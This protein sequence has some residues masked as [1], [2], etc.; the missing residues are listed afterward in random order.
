M[1]D[2]LID[3]N[4]RNSLIGEDDVTP[5]LP[6]RVKVKNSNKALYVH[7]AS[8]VVE[9]PPTATATTTSVAD[10]ASSTDLLASNSARLGA[11]V[12]NDSSA[13]LYINL[14]DAASTSDFTIK[15]E[16]GD[17]WEVPFGFT[18]KLTGIWASDAGGSAKV[19]EY[20]T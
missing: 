15:L 1:A 2:A 13:D 3:R 18:G 4:N 10:S 20:T 11:A 16:Q 8:S 9:N 7:I 17:Y 6:Q 5:S 12:F 19:T 14:T